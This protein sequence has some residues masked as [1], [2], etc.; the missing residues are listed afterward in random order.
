MVCIHLKVNSKLIFIAEEI[1]AS[2]N[3][4][5]SNKVHK[6]KRRNEIDIL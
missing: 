4:R 3:I 1:K 6:R 5:L 2:I